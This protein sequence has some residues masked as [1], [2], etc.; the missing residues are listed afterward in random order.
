M[1]SMYGDIFKLRYVLSTAFGSF[2]F[3]QVAVSNEV[4]IRH[5][6]LNETF[7]LPYCL[8]KLYQL[9]TTAFIKCS[10]LGNVRFAISL[11]N[12]WHTVVLTILVLPVKYSSYDRTHCVNVTL[13]ITL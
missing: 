4:V 3:V 11:Q 8:F 12:N 1:L 5:F 13:C 10:S 9:K 6:A 7:L 2:F